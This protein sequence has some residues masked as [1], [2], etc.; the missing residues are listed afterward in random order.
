MQLHQQ[1][2]AAPA[3]VR[4]RSGIAKWRMQSNASDACMAFLWN[5]LATTIKKP[6]KDRPEKYRLGSLQFELE[7]FIKMT[8]RR[9]C[10]GAVC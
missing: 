7:I 5:F 8:E 3:L 2:R 9:L 6:I 1:P 4:C 10:P